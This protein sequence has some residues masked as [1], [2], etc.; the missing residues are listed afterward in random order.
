MFGNNLELLLMSLG[1]AAATDFTQ[2]RHFASYAVEFHPATEVQPFNFVKI[3]LV[4]TP[5]LHVLGVM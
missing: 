1:P 2:E 4:L 5:I 3:F